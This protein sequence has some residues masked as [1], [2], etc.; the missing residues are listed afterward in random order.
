MARAAVEEA[1]LHRLMIVPASIPPH[2]SDRI[3]ASAGDRMRMCE[4]AFSGVPRTECSDIELRREGP[5]Y[6]VDTLEYF[7]GEHPETALFFLMGADAL[8][9]LQSW[10]RLPRVCQLCTFLVA[11]REGVPVERPPDIPGMRLRWLR[12]CPPGINA[13]R[14]REVCA[15]GG[16]FEGLIPSEVAQYIRQRGL[17]GD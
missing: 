11:P 5:S 7:Q 14:V 10:R 17:Y 4:L 12:A 6:T 3:L 9:D 8:L 2:K 16:V 13:T 1:D 15:Q